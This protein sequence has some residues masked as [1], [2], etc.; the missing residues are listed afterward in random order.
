[1]KYC[2]LF[3]IFLLLVGLFGVYYLINILLKMQ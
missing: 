3:L 2:K 1:M